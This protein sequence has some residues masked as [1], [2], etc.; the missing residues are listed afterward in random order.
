MEQAL[1]K[2][3]EYDLSQTAIDT[4]IQSA[5]NASLKFIA[6]LALVHRELLKPHTA[7]PSRSQA[8][9]P[10]PTQEFSK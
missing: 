5:H 4:A 2:D 10:T 8:T 3:P 6:D 7:T 9:S 1:E